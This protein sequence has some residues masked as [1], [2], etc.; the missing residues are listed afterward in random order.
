MITNSIM[1]EHLIQKF[2][3]IALQS[4]IWAKTGG[5]TG[6]INDLGP[7]ELEEIYYMFFPKEKKR[8][9]EEEYIRIRDENKI[10]A[11]RSTILKD[12]QYIGLYEPHNWKPFNDFMMKLSP[13]KKPLKNYKLNEFDSLIKQFKSLRSKYNKAAKIPGSKEWYHKNKLPMPSVN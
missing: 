10:K 9:L 13:L 8:T 5:R 2:S 4:S 7:E 6:N 1:K 12:A 11:L 3:S